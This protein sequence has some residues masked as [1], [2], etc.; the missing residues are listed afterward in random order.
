MLREDTSEVEDH[1]SGIEYDIKP[2]IVNYNYNFRG[3]WIK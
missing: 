1:T 3:K 2:H